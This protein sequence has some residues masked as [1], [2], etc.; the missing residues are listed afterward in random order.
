[1]IAPEASVLIPSEM[2]TKRVTHIFSLRKEIGI[3][4]QIVNPSIVVIHDEGIGS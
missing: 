2:P 1:M 4:K 3:T